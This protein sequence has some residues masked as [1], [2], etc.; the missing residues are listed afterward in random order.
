MY[1]KVLAPGLLLIA[2]FSVSL[3]TLQTSATQQ[4]AAA[5]SPTPT[6]SRVVVL[7]QGPPPEGLRGWDPPSA[8]EVLS[9]QNGKAVKARSAYVVR[10]VAK[11]LAAQGVE[12]EA[13]L[14]Q[15]GSAEQIKQK[16]QPYTRAASSSFVSGETLSGTYVAR[17]I[18]LPEKLKVT[19]DVLILADRII[20]D[21]EK[22]VIKGPHD[23][24]IIPLESV[25]TTKKPGT[26]NKRQSDDP[27]ASADDRIATLLARNTV[28]TGTVTI[29]ASGRG[30]DDRT[31]DSSVTELLDDYEDNRSRSPGLNG[32]AGIF[33][34]KAPNGAD[35]PNPV[36]GDCDDPSIGPNGRNNTNAG[37]GLDGDRG[38][39]APDPG[40]PGGATDGGNGSPIY[41]PIP[42]DS[43]ITQY[44]F[45]SRGGPGGNGGIGGKGGD[46]GDGGNA[47]RGGHGAT[48]RCIVGNGGRAG[49]A[50]DGG[51]GGDGGYGGNGA[52]GGNGGTIVINRPP[53]YPRERIVTDVDRGE[54]GLAGL[55]GSGG[56]PGMY[57]NVAYGGYAGPPACG[58]FG[59]A[60][61]TGN[62]GQGG[63]YGTTGFPGRPGEYGRPGT[64][65][66]ETM[67]ITNGDPPG[68]GGG[69]PN[70]CTTYYWVAY[71]SWDGGLTWEFY[72]MWTA[73][74][75]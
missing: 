38:G 50:G 35:S 70:G 51:G 47:K 68:G 15:R 59:S 24:F 55:G 54:R 48:C 23:I 25:I 69:G 73:G 52:N 19:S 28:V 71:V 42:N 40:Q 44:R 43:Q 49:D 72:D 36:D 45:F 57:G 41:Y 3:S 8:D 14:L 31:S 5:L 10:K 58:S 33:R 30:R 75:W 12:I 63:S 20:F 34:P 2:L 18:V 65:N 26:A 13:A 32:E 27:N 4:R 60:G 21:G 17:D 66:V 11:A 29:D 62:V 67:L 7:R 16:L 37:K 61:D 53:T 6:P 9:Y 56:S 64:S 22:P 1:F 74:C 39:D 46:G